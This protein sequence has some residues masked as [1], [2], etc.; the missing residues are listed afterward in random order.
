MGQTYVDFIFKVTVKQSS[1]RPSLISCLGGGVHLPVSVQNILDYTGHITG[2]HNKDAK[3]VAE[4]FFDT[5]NDLDPEK[6]LVE[7]HMLYGPSVDKGSKNIEGFLSY[8]FMYCW[9]RLYIP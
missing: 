9:R 2:G 8:A 4:S 7:L 3:F 5:M 6:K 1:T